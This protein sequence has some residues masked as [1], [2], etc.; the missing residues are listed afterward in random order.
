MD[1]EYAG[2]DWGDALSFKHSLFLVGT[3]MSTPK[4]NRAVVDIGLKSTSAECGVPQPWPG[5]PY[6]CIAINDEHT[7]LHAAR[8]H[9]LP[10]L[11]AQVRLVP[12]DRK[13]TR[14]NS[15]H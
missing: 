1:V 14:L 9:H 2:I 13:S 8:A 11:G 7:I 3:V 6:R 10:A 12:G 4:A 5:S 15:S